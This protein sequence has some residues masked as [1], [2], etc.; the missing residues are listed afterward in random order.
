MAGQSSTSACQVNMVKQH[1]SPKYHMKFKSAKKLQQTQNNVHG[2]VTQHDH[3]ETSS[4]HGG[5]A[6]WTYG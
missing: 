2:G 4:K 5:G 6:A 3:G 1:G